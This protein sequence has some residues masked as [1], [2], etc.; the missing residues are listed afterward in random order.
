MGYFFHFQAY[1]LPHAL[2]C[3]YVSLFKFDIGILKQLNIFFSLFDWFCCVLNTL[4]LT[5]TKSYIFI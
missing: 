5:I 1:T 3:I 2:N 4:V